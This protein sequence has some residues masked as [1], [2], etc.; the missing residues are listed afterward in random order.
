VVVKQTWKSGDTIE[1]TTPFGLREEGFRDNPN[2][3]AIL[4]GPL[5]L[6]AAIDTSK[7]YP[8]IVGDDAQLFASLQPAAGKPNTFSDAT[9]FRIPGEETNPRV[10]LEPFYKMH[11]DRRYVVYFDR[12]TPAQWQ[13]RQVEYRAESARTRELEARTVDLV[14]PGNPQN[15]RDHQLQ[16]ERTHDG[17]FAEHKYRDADNGWFSWEVKVLP[18]QAQE[19]NVT[20]WGDDVGRR[21][22]VFVDGAKIASELTG[23]REPKFRDRVYPLSAEKLKGKQKVTVKF[24]AATNSLAGGVFGLRVLK[25]KP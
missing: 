7:P 10:T 18:D 12:F 2:R 13:A 4:N 11:G 24:Q 14:L 6:G 17:D 15:E 25:P 22:D 21:F 5:V 16:G 23:Q 20:Y 1:I 19:L 9:S 3:F 8:A